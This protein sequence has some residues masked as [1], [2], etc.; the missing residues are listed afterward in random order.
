MKRFTETDKWADAPSDLLAFYTNAVLD[1]WAE[2]DAEAESAMDLRKDEIRRKKE[3][4]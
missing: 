2:R 3:A 1:A 4:E